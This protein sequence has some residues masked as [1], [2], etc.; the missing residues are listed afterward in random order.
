MLIPAWP[1]MFILV[2]FALIAYVVFDFLS[3][4]KEK[5]KVE[6]V[7]NIITVPILILTAVTFTLP[8][9]PYITEMF[10]LYTIFST[11]YYVFMKVILPMSKVEYI[12]NKHTPLLEMIAK[13]ATYVGF[14]FMMFGLIGPLYNVSA[15]QPERPAWD[16]GEAAWDKFQAAWEKYVDGFRQS[17]TASRA[18]DWLG[19]IFMTAAVVCLIVVI[20]FLIIDNRDKIFKKKETQIVTAPAPETKEEELHAVE[21][22]GLDQEEPSETG[23]EEPEEEKKVEEPKDS[24]AKPKK[25]APKKA[26]PKL[27]EVESVEVEVEVI[28]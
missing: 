3:M 24:T 8:V 19:Y 4:K 27:E 18:F 11:V 6:K 23:K 5:T 12:A 28:E 13:I 17:A 20:A 15:K 2:V 10:F 14:F 22:K 16:A 7:L 1:G 9:H 21:I 26:K 25:A